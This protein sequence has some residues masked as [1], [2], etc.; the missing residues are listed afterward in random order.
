MRVGFIGLGDQ[1]G[2][3]AR[4][5][6]DSGIDTTL[7]ARREATLEPFRDSDAQYAE[8]PAELAAAS[9]LV[10][11]CVFDDAGVDDVLHGERGVFAGIEQGAT[12]AIHST[13]HPTTIHRIADEAAAHGVRLLDAPVSGGGAVAAA[14]K[15]LVIVGGDA[16]VYEQC[17]PVFATYGDPIVHIGPVGSGQL[18]KLVNNVLFAANLRLAN[19]A[20]A[21]GSQF[22]LDPALLAQV[23]QNGS[24]ASY[25]VGVVANTGGSLAPFASRAGPLLR[26][27]VGIVDAVAGLRGAET[28]MLVTVADGLLSGDRPSAFRRLDAPVA[29]IR[30]LRPPPRA[31]RAKP[32]SLT[33]PQHLSAVDREQLT[34][35][36]PGIVRSEE[37]RGV[38]DVPRGPHRAERNESMPL[39]LDDAPIHGSTPSEIVDRHRSVDQ[40]GKHCVHSD[41]VLRVLQRQRSGQGVHTGLRQHVRE[42]LRA[43]DQRGNRRHVDDRPGTLRTHHREHVLAHQPHG[44]EVRGHHRDPTCLA[45]APPWDARRHR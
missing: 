15:L 19:D 8:S 32:G 7:W 18:A 17:A 34:S 4:R 6:V 39:A 9:D 33:A 43:A 27:D 22:E 21:L 30:S 23:L 40:P 3:M 24:G 45:R 28:G 1:G 13:V 36:E 2:P 38:R 20:L 37:Q 16:D 12:I 14:G 25:S 35:D 42:V 26:K 44:L 5:I 31:I 41:P 11:I 10:A 29:R